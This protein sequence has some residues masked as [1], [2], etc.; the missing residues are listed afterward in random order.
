MNDSA[1]IEA[2]L[3]DTIHVRLGVDAGIDDRLDSLGVD[4]LRLADF[5]SDLEKAFGFRADQDI[6]DVETIRELAAYVHER[7]GK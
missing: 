7:G 5:V 2:R 6:F 3:L 4:S 1:D